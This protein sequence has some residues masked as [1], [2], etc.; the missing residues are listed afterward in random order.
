MKRGAMSN[1]TIRVP[2]ELMDRVREIA[3]RDYSRES[4]VVRRLLRLGIEADAQGERA[5]G[6][7]EPVQAA[8]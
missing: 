6:P 2:D 3:A 5:I 1:L 7:R 4:V 8:S